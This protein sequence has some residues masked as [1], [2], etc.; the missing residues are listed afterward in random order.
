M[1]AILICPTQGNGIPALSKT[2]PLVTLPFLGE[3][4]IAYWFQ[5]FAN[6]KIKE[7]RLV[8]TDPVSDLAQYSGSGSRWGLKI[9]V[10]HE[11]RDL[12]VS[13][14]RR[15]Y[16]P[17]HDSDWPAEPNDVVIADHFPGVPGHKLFENYSAWFRAMS[18]WLPQM[19]ASRRVGQKEVE[20]GIW[21][22]RRTKLA[23]SAEIVAPC[24]I[25]DNVRIGSQTQIGPMAFL[26]DRV[27]IE[28]QA[29]VR[30]SWV[31]PDTLVGKL[32]ELMNSLAWGT[33]LINWKTGSYTAIPDPFL[34]ASLADTKP[35]PSSEIKSSPGVHR[36]FTKPF[37]AM[38]ALAQKLQG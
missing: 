10:F 29:L 3:A 35:V 37:E 18:L 9:E 32:T 23:R 31:G 15:R 22:G 6:E 36:P 26:E 30:N 33:S 7:L 21:I 2:K 27:V 34:L 14:A 38:V 11:V 25:G 17:A 20:P 12:T 1:K 28:E 4:F 13:E 5:H 8:T 24:W 16:K 19:A